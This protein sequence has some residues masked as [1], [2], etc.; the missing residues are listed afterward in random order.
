MLEHGDGV[1]FLDRVLVLQILG[2]WR[3]GNGNSNLEY[4]VCLE[5]FSVFSRPSQL[6]RLGL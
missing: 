4:N 2:F 1:L 3:F 5:S 6:S